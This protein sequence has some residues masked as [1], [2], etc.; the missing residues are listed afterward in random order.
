MVFYNQT[1][2]AVKE[3]FKRLE[4]VG[5]PTKRPTDFFCEQVKSDSHMNRVISII[6]INNNIPTIII[7]TLLSLYYL[8]IIRSKID[9]Y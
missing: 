3:G 6:I 1:V 2:L 8:L 4:A 7:I 9:Y 5:Y